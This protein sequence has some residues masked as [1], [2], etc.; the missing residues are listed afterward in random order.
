MADYA[1]VILPL[2]VQGTF[3]YLVPEEMQCDISRGSR[4]YVPFGPRKLYT[5]IVADLHTNTPKFKVKPIASLLDGTSILRHP[6]LKFWQ[7]IA[8]YYLCTLG[9][10]Y[11]AAV[12]T[13]LKVES[14]TNLS[15]NK[16]IDL[17]EIGQTLTPAET[18]LLNEVIVADHVRMSDLDRERSHATTARYVSRML[19]KGIIVADEKATSSYKAKTIAIVS[20]CNDVKNHEWLHQAFDAVTTATKQERLLISFLELIK[21]QAVPEI[22][23]EELL[24]KAKVSPGILKA[25][26]DKGILKVEKRKINRFDAK[27]G[28]K[29]VELPPLSPLQREALRQ[30]DEQWRE[31]NVVLLRGITGSGK[32]EIYCHA[33]LSALEAGHQVLYLVPEISLTTQLTDRLRKVFGNRLLVY[34]SKFSDSE[35]VDI[36]R[37]LLHSHEPMVI[38]G[39]RS[40]VF[41]PFA[42]IGLVVVD[43]EHEAS[44]KQY[45]P[46]PRYNARDAAIM[47]AHLHGAKTLL[48]SATPAID[49]YYKAQ[50]GKFGLV[51]LLERYQGA[52]LPDVTVVDM[53]DSRKRRL[54]DGLL[55][56]P[57]AENLR[58]TIKR[59]RQAIMFQNRRG[60]APLIQCTQCGWQPKC[61]YCDVSMVYHKSID[62]MS[63]HYCGYQMH[64]PRLCPAC[65]QNS[66]RIGGYG[67]E[68]I[69]E[70]LHSHFPEARVS[71][72]DLDTTR[73]KD[74]YQEIIEDF[75]GH[76]TDILIGTQMVSKGLDFANVSMVGV[77]NAD[78]LLHFP[79]FRA[80]ERAFNMLVQVAG[81]AGRRNEQGQ[82]FIQTSDAANPLLKFISSQDY[83]GYYEYELE[84]RRRFGYPPFTKIIM[85]YVK[86]R[87]EAEAARLATRYAGELQ[88]VFGT[89]V[90]G[91]AKPSVARISN[92]YIQTIM[93]KIEAVASMIK[94]KKLLFEIYSRMAADRS[95]RNAQVYYDVDPV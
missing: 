11:R 7:W 65:G 67:T 64:L 63:C 47:L 88:K 45:D 42:K 72:M 87:E 71:R 25:I 26:C 74:A 61:Q 43:E 39:V 14:E 53:L 21:N 12:P 30:I 19:Q 77:V 22:T 13:G 70:H 29:P 57:V 78:S 20:A 73:N 59:G 52:Q 9:E 8:D 75:A 2:A 50:T 95:F 93:L 81:R 54:T 18:E 79:D 36:W 85:L 28:N 66:V 83:S 48:G 68:R 1:E 15:L 23:R 33:I 84:Q 82:V 60:F 31:K 24:T 27:P 4:V 38:L 40:S 5:G 90:L 46:A 62:V 58:H 41:L 35:R 16:A 80:N 44:Y 94:V 49:T 76:N 55:A 6:Q 89:R 17:E 69:A 91:P 86:H 92:Y 32:T 34:H 10:V 51:E 3:T 37:K 56:N